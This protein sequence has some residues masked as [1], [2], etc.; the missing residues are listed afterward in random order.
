MSTSSFRMPGDEILRNTNSPADALLVRSRGGGARASRAK[1]TPS[2]NGDEAALEIASVPMEEESAKSSVKVRLSDATFGEGPWTLQE[3]VTGSVKAEFEGEGGDRHVTLELWVALPGEDFTFAAKRSAKVG[4]GGRATAKFFLD[5]PKG[6]D[7]EGQ[8]VTRCAFVLRASHPDARIVESPEI[9]AEKGS[10]KNF[11]GVVYYAPNQDRYLILETEEVIEDFFAEVRQVEDL[12]VKARQAWEAP[13]PEKRM[14]ALEEVQTQAEKVFGGKTTGDAKRGLE[15]LFLVQDSR[16]KG[17]S[18]GCVYSPDKPKDG[19]KWRL[20]TATEALTEKNK[21]AKYGGQHKKVE[22]D[23]KIKAALWEPGSKEWPEGKVRKPPTTDDGTSDYFTWT[24]EATMGR[25]FCGWDGGA[26]SYDPKKKT[27]KIGMSGNLTASVYEGKFRGNMDLPDIHGADLLHCIKGV[28]YR[29]R[30][31]ADPTRACLLKVRFSGEVSAFLGAQV[32]GALA[33]PSVSFKDI[34]KDKQSA[35]VGGSVSGFVGL[36]LKGGVTGGVLWAPQTGAFKDLGKI[37]VVVG[38]SLGAGAEIQFKVEFKEGKFRF[39]FG[40]GAAWLLGFKTGFDWEVGLWEGCDL[41]GHLLDCLDFHFVKEILGDAYLIYASHSLG[42]PLLE[43][44]RAGFIGDWYKLQTDW[45]GRGLESLRRYLWSR[46]AEMMAVK[47]ALKQQVGNR[48]A[49][50]RMAP[51]AMGMAL[52]LMMETREES[53]FK[54]I[55]YILGSTLSRKDGAKVKPSKDHKLK[56]VLRTV[57]GAPSESEKKSED[58]KKSALESGILKLKKF[59]Y[60]VDYP[61]NA[62]PNEEFKKELKIILEE[63]E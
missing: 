45:A 40:A 13:D 23:G 56:W 42:L 44:Q 4:K 6:S 36:Q 22:L 14:E 63:I 58:W 16:K 18:I 24:R 37:G 33:F 1:A 49:L 41:I 51:E 61:G 27:L 28:K 52:A 59:G 43:M 35:E 62:R 57:G 29:D 31:L 30:Y 26:F 34:S 9:E 47:A 46:E 54:P 10:H 15:E 7:S 12:R 38:G 19:K 39:L 48:S 60:S 32:Q 3:E 21:I 2:Q 8:V 5:P 11:E 55:L 25:F 20:L 50:T 53:D 17:I